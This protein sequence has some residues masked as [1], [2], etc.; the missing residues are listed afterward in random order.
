M[1]KI[2]SLSDLLTQ[3][4][5]YQRMRQAY[6]TQTLSKI[7]SQWI[8]MANS[9][10]SSR[11][12]KTKSLASKTCQHLKAPTIESTL[13]K[14]LASTSTRS[15]R[16]LPKKHLN[17]SARK[18]LHSRKSTRRCTTLCPFSLK[19]KIM[20]WSSTESSSGI[21]GSKSASQHSWKETIRSI[22]GKINSNLRRQS[23]R[24]LGEFKAKYGWTRIT[25]Q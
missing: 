12:S 1:A 5:K 24:S 18:R 14:M 7:F 4:G 23:S 25:S 3:L 20:A 15:S 21:L 11:R 22:R 13:V 8:F 16:M 10:Q 6:W 2:M 17:T 19:N 9:Y